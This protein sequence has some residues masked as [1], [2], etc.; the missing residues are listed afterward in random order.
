MKNFTKEYQMISPNDLVR[1]DEHNEA[2][3]SPDEVEHEGTFASYEKYGRLNPVYY[4]ER[5][6]DGKTINACIDGWK[7][8]VF[9]QKNGTEEI[10]A[11]KLTVESAEDLVKIMIQLQGSDHGSYQSLFKMIQIL[12]PI[13]YK[14]SGFRSDL[15]GKDTES[16]DGGKR[17][18]IYDR[19]GRDLHISGNKVKHLRKVGLVNPLYFERMEVDR[20]SL[21][22]AYLNCKKEEKGEMSEVPTVKAPVYFSST[23]AM[24]A[25]S[26]ASTTADVMTETE[27]MISTQLINDVA[28]TGT[29]MDSATG[30]EDTTATAAKYTPDVEDEFII[31]RGI[32][33]CCGEETE[34]KINKNQL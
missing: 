26:K 8:V 3:S 33:Q 11:Y 30:V 14:G 29:R 5:I 34:I 32:C 16:A 7:A 25:F 27:T 13:Y 23:T 12:W 24:P 28:T 15:Q 19:I 10:S 31:V 18:N 9:A 1:A 21:Y 20:C 4:Y 2:F 6:E 22:G 17:L